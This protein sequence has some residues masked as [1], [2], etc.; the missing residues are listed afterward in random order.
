MSQ[1]SQGEDS[2][3]PRDDAQMWTDQDTASACAHPAGRKGIIRTNVEPES[4]SRPTAIDRG[5]RHPVHAHPIVRAYIRQRVADA[6]DRLAERHLAPVGDD[7][8]TASNISARWSQE[9]IQ[10]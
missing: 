4:L 2:V 7:P 10:K 1:A 5:E 6:F 8:G 3:L 9:W